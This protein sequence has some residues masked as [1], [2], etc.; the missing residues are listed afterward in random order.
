[1]SEP[2]DLMVMEMAH[3][4]VK[5]AAPYLEKCTAKQLYVQHVF[6]LD[7]YPQIEALSGKYGYPV[8]TPRDGDEVEL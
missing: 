8:F 5:E 3:F 1:M 4:G 6:P 7:K 2:L